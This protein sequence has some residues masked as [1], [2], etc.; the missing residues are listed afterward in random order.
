V[1]FISSTLTDYPP[2]DGL[3]ELELKMIKLSRM[4]FAQRLA[5]WMSCDSNYLADQ[6]I[7][8]MEDYIRRAS[9]A[10]YDGFRLQFAEK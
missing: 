4:M 7:T 2:F 10:L 3:G 1:A 6:G 9:K 5:H 8:D